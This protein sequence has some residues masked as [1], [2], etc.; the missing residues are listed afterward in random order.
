MLLF[1]FICAVQCLHLSVDSVLESPSRYLK[2]PRYPDLLFD[3]YDKTDLFAKIN[4]GYPGLQLIHERPYVFLVNNFFSH[5]ECDR[6]ITKLHEGVGRPQLGGGSVVRT[7]SGVV[8]EHEEVPTIRRK[9]M[10]LTNTAPAQLQWLKISRYQAGQEFSKH[11]DAWVTEGAPLCRGWINEED[12][13][14][15]LKRQVSGCLHALNQPLHNNYMTVFVY[16]NDVEQGGCTTFPNIGLHT[17]KAGSSFYD[18]PA[19]LDSRVRHDGT[20]WDWDFG[21]PLT[22]SPEKGMAIL[23]FCSLIPEKGGLCDGNTFHCAEPPAQGQEKYVSQQFFSSCSEWSLHYDSL[24]Q[25]RVS[26]DTI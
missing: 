26:A 16:L 11:T 7:S 17:G 3:A 19:P 4:L 21:V 23:H 12:V 18:N 9:M 6:L 25:G 22:I 10:E 24:P 8:C 13:F 2:N 5:D 15:D 20:S 1:G 14:G